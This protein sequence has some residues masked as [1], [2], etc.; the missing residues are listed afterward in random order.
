[1]SLSKLNKI[2]EDI[3]ATFRSHIDGK[4]IVLS[5]EQSIRIQ[6]SLN[7]DILMVMNE[8]PKKRNVP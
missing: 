7:S 4:K 6:K 3:G 1:M 8:C 5:P 2:D